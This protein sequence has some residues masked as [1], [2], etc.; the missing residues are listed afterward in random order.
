MTCYESQHLPPNEWGLLSVCLRL[1]R[2]GKSRLFFDGRKMAARFSGTSK[3]SIYRL[4]A[5]LVTA[6]WLVPLNGVGRKNAEG[7]NRYEATQYR[8]L[9]HAE[10]ITT[11]GTS[12]CAVC[13][14]PFP[15]LGMD[16]QSI[17]KIA[18]N[19]SQNSEKPF[20]PAGH[21]FVGTVFVEPFVPV[22]ISEDQSEEQLRPWMRPFKQVIQERLKHNPD[23]KCKVCA[24]TGRVSVNHLGDR[25]TMPCS[26]RRD[27]NANQPSESRN[28]DTPEKPESSCAL[29]ASA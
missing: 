28:S 27:R 18:K 7:N 8:V 23:P 5:R 16:C 29:G 6:G 13:K 20:P 15:S 11:Y 24:G 9:T 25:T 21:S 4:A 26:C 1:S 22:K 17:P 12:Q 2:G 3:T 19:H 10:W 14:D